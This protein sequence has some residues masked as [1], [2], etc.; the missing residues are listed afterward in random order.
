MKDKQPIFN[1]EI[2]QEQAECLL[3]AV[4]LFLN[5]RRD[6]IGELRSLRAAGLN[7][8]SF[9]DILDDIYSRQIEVS[10]PLF[11]ELEKIVLY[12]LSD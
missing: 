8:N 3:S 2:T 6:R 12:G 11:D 9:G 5:K 4:G 10:K 1:L 7:K